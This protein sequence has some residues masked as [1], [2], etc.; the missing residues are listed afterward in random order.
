MLVLFFLNLSSNEQQ[1]ITADGRLHLVSIESRLYYDVTAKYV[2]HI[3]KQ[4]LIH[5]NQ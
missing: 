4:V 3:N 2:K 1:K 5:V